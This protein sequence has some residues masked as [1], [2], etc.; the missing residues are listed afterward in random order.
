[1]GS[2][3]LGGAVLTTHL[4]IGALLLAGCV[5]LTARSYRHVM[6]ATEPQM[7]AAGVKGQVAPA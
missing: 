3:L 4:A 2:T 6:L 1:M 5:I 7:E